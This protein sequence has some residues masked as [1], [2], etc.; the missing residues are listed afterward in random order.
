M[1]TS[2]ICREPALNLEDY[3]IANLEV[4]NKL[5]YI[6]ERST[7]RRKLE[8]W[9]L[10]PAHVAGTRDWPWS[11]AERLSIQK[12]IMTQLEERKTTKDL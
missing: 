12:S 1:D 2:T 4:W 3:R 11:K 10:V 6:D 7:F 8:R 9:H 5:V